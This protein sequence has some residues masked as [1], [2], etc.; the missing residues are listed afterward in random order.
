MAVGF[1][2]GGAAGVDALRVSYYEGRTLRFAG[3][4]R[5]GFVP[6][7]RRELLSRLKPLTFKVC[8]FAN[9]PDT[10]SG[11]WGGGVTVDQ[12]REMGWVR[13][14]L[15]AQIRFAQWTSEGRLRHAAYMG[16]RDGKEAREVRREWHHRLVMHNKVDMAARKT[17]WSLNCRE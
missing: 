7:V 8:P 11:R 5:A 17:T 3:K 4:V 13:P 10:S 1:G 15:G 9:L 6:R 14:K 12:M 2:H 16:M